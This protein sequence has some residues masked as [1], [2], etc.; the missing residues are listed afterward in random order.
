MTRMSGVWKKPFQKCE[1]C[2]EIQRIDWDVV[3]LPF[4]SDH[5]LIN[6]C[7]LSYHMANEPSTESQFQL[8]EWKIGVFPEQVSAFEG[9][10]RFTEEQPRNSEGAKWG[11]DNIL[12]RELCGGFRRRGRKSIFE[13][14]SVWP[15]DSPAGRWGVKHNDLHLAM[16]HNIIAIEFNVIVHIKAFFNFKT[17]SNNARRGWTQAG[18]VWKCRIF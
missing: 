4:P 8:T 13:P 17:K 1:I 5:S 12:W 11:Q 18:R 9:E 6:D 10:P 7:H 15:S 16:F 2:G 14:K 3:K